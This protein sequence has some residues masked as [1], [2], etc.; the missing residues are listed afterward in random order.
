MLS[1][2]LGC[3]IIY[4][5]PS[6]QNT[7][8]YELFNHFIQE[9]GALFHSEAYQGNKLKANKFWAI[10]KK[11]FIGVCIIVFLSQFHPYYPKYKMHS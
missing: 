7:F 8:V 1:Y 9:V 5:L 2:H 11:S 6:I 4:L 3:S 10:N